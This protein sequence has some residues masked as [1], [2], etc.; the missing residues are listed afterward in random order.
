[1]EKEKLE[2]IIKFLSEI[3]SL[4]RVRR[5]G[6]WL[7]GVENTPSVTDHIA[8]SAQ[9][10]YILAKLEGADANKCAVINLFHDTEQSRIGNQHKVSSRYIDRT[11]AKQKAKED[12]CSN[13]PEDVKQ[14]ILS[15]QNELKE[16]NTKEGIICQ[17]A[18]WLEAA[19]QSKIYVERGYKGMENWI[20]NVEEALETESAKEILKEM[21]ENPD[22]VNYW[23]R[24]LEKMTYK[25]LN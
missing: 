23:W 15:L 24:G 9:I 10:A 16:R 12:Q 2:K 8:V 4:K 18:E 13:L 14:E 1:M 17:D 22:F 5:E 21:K 19:L 7:A 6:P 11:E 3:Q 20:D 25:K